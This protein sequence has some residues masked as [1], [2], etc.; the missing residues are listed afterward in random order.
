MSYTQGWKKVIVSGSSAELSEVS[1]SL[2]FSG[3][4][5]NLLIGTPTDGTY[6]DG[7][8]NTFT[9]S[10]KLPDALDEISEAFLDIAPAKA[11]NL[12]STNLTRGT[13]VFSGYLPSGLNSNWYVNGLSANNIC[14]VL[15]TN[16]TLIAS[17]ASVFNVGTKTN[18][19]ASNLSGTNIVNRALGTGSLLPLNT[20]Q[21]SGKTAG[22]YST[23]SLTSVLAVFNTIWAS[24]TGVIN[25]TVST[26][27][28]VRYNLSN[29]SAGT[30]NTLQYVYTGTFTA[31]VLSGVQLVESSSVQYNYL[32][33]VPYYRTATFKVAL[34]GSNLYNP[35]YSLT[36]ASLAST[37][38]NTINTGSTSPA[39]DDV[40]NVDIS[41]TINGNT[42]SGQTI[43]T[44]TVTLF[45]PNGLTAASSVTLGAFRINSY[46]TKQSTGQIEYFL[47]EY[48]R[49][50][51]LTDFDV[52]EYPSSTTLS[53][54][55]LQVQNG[56]LI[57]GT[58]GDYPSFTSTSNVYYR[59]VTPVNAFG[60]KGTYAFT[61]NSGFTTISPWNSG[62]ALEIAFAR[63]ADF[64]GGTPSVIW[65]FGR[66]F[67]N[68]SGTIN[69]IVNGTAGS[70]SGLFTM[71][72]ENVGTQD[73]VLMIRYNGAIS[74]RLS[75]LNL[76]ITT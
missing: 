38:F 63:I 2:G 19:N 61:N 31:P 57:R 15:T 37:Y 55:N 44:A 12:T 49:L 56:R 75:Q 69:G 54:G 8:F 73:V 20:L 65:D 40:L 58:A 24:S 39:V 71:G 68:N 17:A 36:Q 48:Y 7:F 29:T 5:T 74:S 26:T 22:S 25:N 32:S 59:V 45:K 64:S 1:A 67:G 10:S 4:G 43:P 46:N 13:S 70:L 14:S 16:A 9:S 51:S 18:L 47:D 30:S 52:N 50:S 21:L 72:T 34:T 11:G 23:G 42:N 35:V 41:A 3:D 76:Q 33:G 60:F 28:S 27:G 66:A 62:G 6:T 53:D